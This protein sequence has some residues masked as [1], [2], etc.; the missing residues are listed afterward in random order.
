MKI[1]KELPVKVLGNGIRE[2]AL[3]VKAHNSKE[4]LKQYLQQ[5][6]MLR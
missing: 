4:P 6:E 2:K 5:V 1:I 3:T